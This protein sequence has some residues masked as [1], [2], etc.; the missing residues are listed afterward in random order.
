MLG[1]YFLRS[2]GGK[3]TVSARTALPPL[4]AHGAT[5][6]ALAG[7][8]ARA[9]S[10][11]RR[12]ANEDEP[13]PDTWSGRLPLRELRRVLAAPFTRCWLADQQANNQAPRPHDAPEAFAVGPGAD[14][15]LIFG[16]GPAVGWGVLSND[17]ALPGSVARALRVKTGRGTTVELVADMRIAVSNALPLLLAIDM[18]RFDVIVIVLGGN[19][20]V[21]LM[22]LRI[23]R[24]R[25]VAVLGGV[26]Q[27]SLGPPRTF[28]TG[29]PPIDFVPGFQTR[30]GKMIAAHAMEMN[31]AT[32]RLCGT[33]NATYI[34]LPGIEPE[35]EL[36]V[37]DG[38]T[39]RKW[40]DA[41]ADIIAPQ[42]DDL[43]TQ[44]RSHQRRSHPS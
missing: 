23:W 21:R 38:Q 29:I 44:P 14:R 31:S 11:A 3:E 26:Q 1:R 41:I 42:L 6:A 36:G 37:R 27:K 13:Q 35:N 9:G 19:D 15:V 12:T 17:I 2:S 7:K 10:P 25:F 40:A 16:S 5:D 20:A 33:V 24:K 8:S 32:A 18:S 34:P 28:V 4:A 43:K 22:P 39:Y 30:L